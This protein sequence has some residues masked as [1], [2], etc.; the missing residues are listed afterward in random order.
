MKSF[1]VKYNLLKLLLLALIK[2]EKFKEQLKGLELKFNSKR[3]I[4]NS[5]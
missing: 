3:K 5:K 1:K 2:L 4:Y